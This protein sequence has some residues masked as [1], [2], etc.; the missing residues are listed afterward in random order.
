M[1][2]SFL[3]MNRASGLRTYTLML[4]DALQR[5][6]E[7][8][9]YV[10]FYNVFRNSLPIPQLGRMRNRVWRVPR[11][12][13]EMAWTRLHWPPV[14]WLTG[15][16]D[17]FHS[18]HYMVPPQ[19]RGASVLT[20]HDL[21]EFRFP[22]LYPHWQGKRLHRAKMAR[23]AH[24]I[25]AVSQATKDDAVNYLQLEPD[26]ITVVHNGIDARFLSRPQEP[27]R[28]Q[29]LTSLGIDSPY[30]LFVSSE[31]VRKGMLDA[32]QAFA[33][34][35]GCGP[36]GPRLVVAGLLPPQARQ[37]L[38]QSGVQDRVLLLGL[39]SDRQLQCLL[40]GALALLFLSHYEGFGIP[41]L[42]AF[43]SGTAVVGYATSA[44][45]EVAGEAAA[46]H[47][48]QDIEGVTQ[49]LHRLV[50]DQV[51]RQH[52]ISQ[53]EAR[54]SQFSWERA[55]RQVRDVYQVAYRKS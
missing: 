18:L 45:P 39:V 7:G 3:A 36:N 44:M 9:E 6:P 29:V 10:G 50:E 33:K 53:G 4:L 51:W 42:E 25:I 24:Q 30:F 20:I 31:D 1:D 55:A 52:L 28:Q 16:V 26:K 11:R 2:T 38:A 15:P 27:E 22:E 40:C 47:P 17:V 43:A 23:R 49:S 34:M 46:L 54:L 13:L 41:I 14:D 48:F 12:L 32:L 21:R 8:D 5:L 35:K 19:R 37:L